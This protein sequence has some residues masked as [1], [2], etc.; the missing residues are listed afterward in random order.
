M[1]S[2]IHAVPAGRRRF[3]AA[4]PAKAG[5]P[6]V[7]SALS[8]HHSLS[9]LFLFISLLL[10]LLPL[11]SLTAEDFRILTGAAFT[12]PATGTPHA[13]LRWQAADPETLRTLR[14]AVYAK[15][16]NA[17]SP[18]THTPVGATG[19]ITSPAVINSLAH[20]FPRAHFDP[21]AFSGIIDDLF[22]EFMPGLSLT[23]GD[24]LSFVLQLAEMDPDV[25]SRL[26][27]LAY[28]EPFMAVCMGL[29]A[30]VPMPASVSTF[31][32]CAQAA[33][34]DDPGRPYNVVLG[35][36]TVNADAPPPLPTPPAPEQILD[37]SV[38]GHLNAQL[39]WN[40]TTALLRETPAIFGFDI[41]RM[42]KAFAEA[43]GFDTTP[44]APAIITD[45]LDTA[46]AEV[47]RVNTGAILPVEDGDPDTPFIIDDNDAGFGLGLPFAD[48][49][50]FYYFVAARDL[51]GRPGPL[52]PGTLVTICDR[53]PP[54]SPRRVAVSN[55][56]TYD[57]T[58]GVATT[59]LKI[60]WE[61]HPNAA[62]A[63]P[64]YYR[65]SRWISVT[66][67][68]NAAADN[69]AFEAAVVSPPI[70]HVPGQTVY[71]WIANSS[72]ARTLADNPGETT[73]YTVLAVKDT[74][75]LALVGPP[76]APAWG[77]IRDFE[78]PEAGTTSIVLS[79]TRPK[80]EV[81]FLDPINATQEI[82][83]EYEGNLEDRFWV[84]D[85]TARRLNPGITR[86][87]YGVAA[88]LPGGGFGF[89][90]L[91]TVEFGENANEF[92]FKRRLPI[93]LFSSEIDVRLW[94]IAEDFT[95][96]PAFAQIPLSQIFNDLILPI[97]AE[98]D[99]TT[100]SVNLN[101]GDPPDGI[102]HNPIG[103]GGL[104]APLRPLRFA[105]VTPADAREYKV[106]KRVNGGP[107]IFVTQGTELD[108]PGSIEEIED[109]GFPPYGGELCYFIQW[110]DEHGNPS[111]LAEL[112]CVPVAARAPMPVPL[113]ERP[114]A[115]GTPEA[116]QA[117]LRWFC[118][119]EG[120]ER[121]RVY[122]GDG[123]TPMGSTPS[124][125]TPS[126]IRFDPLPGF[127]SSARDPGIRIGDTTYRPYDT[128][129]VG[130]N[131]GNPFEPGIF[132]LAV[133]V[134]PG[135]EY[136]FFVVAVSAA[137]D[138]SARSNIEPFLWTTPPETPLPEIPW[139][140]RSLPALDSGFIPQ[141][142]AR[143]ITSGGNRFNGAGIRIGNFQ[144][145]SENVFLGGPFLAD[146]IAF[147][148][149]TSFPADNTS[150]LTLFTSVS[151]ETILPCVVYRYEVQGPQDDLV[152]GNI[153][154]VTPLIEDILAVTSGG[155]TT[156]Y[157]P[158]VDLFPGLLQTG[159]YIKDTHPVI[160]GRTYRYLVVRFRP[161]GE[162]D[163]VIR[164]NR[165]F[166]ADLP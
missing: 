3:R 115:I 10:F 162:I 116:P 52:S 145:T 141:I 98:I 108:A 110:F 99:L 125:L 150:T 73:W 28:A 153:V 96:R 154:Q 83:A 130:G 34:G 55:V 165:V 47:R 2:R 101:D 66:D 65:V 1:E 91:G 160:A 60:S 97:L 48:G 82:L 131:F 71:E 26:L 58:T 161:D 9:P 31:E 69:S 94:M 14:T 30:V 119:P 113:L 93:D 67:L 109:L 164:T 17:N 133:D 53:M 155:Q 158:F 132:E 142:A 146:G 107:L 135:R 95:G 72:G 120:V 35:R 11:S 156:L 122:V 78:R 23:H 163:R 27:M 92:H 21:E 89:Q 147:D 144:T 61:A 149:P 41:F 80:I 45:L 37:Y 88:Q 5:T 121:F 106:Y 19:L 46:P 84:V 7:P 151:G 128:G 15:A 134:Q 103:P 20:G 70:P 81:S 148:T 136:N 63:P 4:G 79:S 8:L 32:L 56:R 43:N 59:R 12:D 137:G 16:G 102:V 86:F 159:V 114:L 64:A 68:N 75:C 74:A 49:D 166:I 118:P 6:T 105:V 24:K 140:A 138:R 54:E 22:G 50:Q 124:G 62:D 87:A 44:P 77:A 127:G 104:G 13:Y 29:A 126:V 123:L 33:G 100:V 157:N 42:T 40:T 38:T 18:A 51:L 152:T 39:R 129:R 139:P 85:L 143:H 90:H 112:G 57:S 117:L 25:H 111:P 76:S 36:V